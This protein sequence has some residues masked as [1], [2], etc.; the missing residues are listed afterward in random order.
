MSSWRIGLQSVSLIDLIRQYSTGSLIQAK[1]KVDQLLDG[2]MVS[3]DFA[4]EKLMAEFK[5]K[6]ERLGVIFN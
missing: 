5:I 6:A 2:K 3:L 4:S 1:I